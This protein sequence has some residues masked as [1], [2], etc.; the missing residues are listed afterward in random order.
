MTT[1]IIQTLIILAVLTACFLAFYLQKPVSEQ[2]ETEGKPESKEKTHFIE[3][4]S[5]LEK[6]PTFTLRIDEKN[7]SRF[8]IIGE[9]RGN[10]FSEKSVNKEVLSQLFNELKVRNVQAIFLS[11]N[12]VS[13]VEKG[14][15]GHAKPVDNQK[16]QEE[17]LEFSDL[18]HSK[19]GNDVPVYPALGDREFVVQGSAKS[20]IEEFHL[21]GAKVLG[22]E[23][24]YTVSAGHAFFAV[25]TTNELMDKH[26]NVQESFKDSVL[27]WLDRVLQEGAK[28]HKYL[29]VVGYEPAFPSATTFLKEKL[30]QRDAFWKVLTDNKVL[31]YITSKEHLFDRSNRYG[32]WQIISGGGGAPLSQG[33]GSLPFYHS[34]ILTIP[35]DQEDVEK[36]NKPQGPSVQVID[37]RGYVIEEF[38]LGQEHQ[39]LYQMRIS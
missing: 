33:G 22:N 18:Y 19:F 3:K 32:V 30:P 15:G 34:L 29:F 2:S 38:T 6:T 12:T 11:G 8:G 39:P 9:G 35:G 7:E 16:L 26:G 10:D 1:K 25:I 31:A 4:T 20:F 13:A 37:N 21:Q 23:L 17:L 36:E 5:P 24:L 27:E 14:E 28:T